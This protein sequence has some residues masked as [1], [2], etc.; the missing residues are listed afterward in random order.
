MGCGA[1]GPVG[2]EGVTPTFSCGCEEG[3]R[4]P[5]RGT[6][7]TRVAIRVDGSLAKTEGEAAGSADV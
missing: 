6:L 2:E 5:N 1:V 4:V 3:L 7:G